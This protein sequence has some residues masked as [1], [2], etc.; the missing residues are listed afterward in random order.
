MINIVIDIDLLCLDVAES[1]SISISRF[2]SVYNTE[3]GVTLLQN[4]NNTILSIGQILDFWTRSIFEAKPNQFYSH[5]KV[6]EGVI[7]A[8]S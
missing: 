2:W 5:S 6:L 3:N 1:E 7:F 8:E 4:G